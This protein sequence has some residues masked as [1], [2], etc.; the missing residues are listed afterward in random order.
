MAD[1]F[2]DFDAALA[3]LEEEPLTFKLGGTLFTCVPEIPAGRVLWLARHADKI[4]ADAFAAFA[5]FVESVVVEAQ[6]PALWDA[7]NRV[8]LTTLLELI[9]R[10]IEEAT[11]RPLP[12]AS[13]LPEEQPEDGEPSRVV[14][15]SPVTQETRSA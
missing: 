15:L 5:E 13:S 8:G 9:Q 12:S 4:D 1:R 2:K 10:L 11:G 3:E 7:L 14:S 6:R